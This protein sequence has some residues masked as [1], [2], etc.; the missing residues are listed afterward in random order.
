VLLDEGVVVAGTAAVVVCEE[1]VVMLE[2][3]PNVSV[4]ALAVGDV[5][6]VVAAVVVVAPER[7]VNPLTN[8]TSATRLPASVALRARTAGWRLRRLRA[9]LVVSMPRPSLMS[10]ATP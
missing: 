5:V 7:I 6:T 8:P 3:S 9:A 1:S 10:L 2:S 4:V